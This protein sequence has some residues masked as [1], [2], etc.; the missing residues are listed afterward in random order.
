STV[1]PGGNV[2]TSNNPAALPSHASWNGF[3]ACS[4]VT[5]PSPRIPPMSWI[6]FIAAPPPGANLCHPHHR[7]PRDPIGQISLSE[8]LGSRRPLRD[9]HVSDLCG[10]IPNPHLDIVAQIKAKLAEETARID[11]G[12]RPV[13][14]RFVPSRWQ[15]EEAPGITGA[16]CA[17]DE[18]VDER[19][20]LERDDMLSL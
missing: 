17:N 8:R 20:V 10:R 12:A 11:D 15:P 5:G 9:N 14:R 3:S 7:I 13:R 6:E 19:C 4:T 1:K 16:Q 2:I 18:V